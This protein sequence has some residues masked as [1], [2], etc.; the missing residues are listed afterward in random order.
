MKRILMISAAILV[1]AAS[2][3]GP[4]ARADAAAARAESA[5]QVGTGDRLKVSVYNAEKLSGEYSVGGDGKIAFPM[6]GRIAVAGLTLEEV[7]QLL[8]QR[9]ADGYLLNPNVS[10]DMVAYR[11]VFILGEVSKPGQYPYAE[12]MT[13]Y[14]LVAQAGG[15]S[16]RA[17]RR[18]VRLRHEGEVKEHKYSISNGSPVKPG[19]TVVILQRYF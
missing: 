19:D 18:T 1:G 8:T 12:G 5:Y 7:G 17:N 6:I 2:A 16:Y 3:A 4:I 9:L 13:I 11:S 15:F 10:V 14:Q